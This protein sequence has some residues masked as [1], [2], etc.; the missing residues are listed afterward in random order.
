MNDIDNM[1][2]VMTAFK[3]GKTIQGKYRNGSDDDWGEYV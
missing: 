3:G 2:A 1:I